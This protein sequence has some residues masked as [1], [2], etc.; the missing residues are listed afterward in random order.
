MHYSKV[1]ALDILEVVLKKDDYPSAAF[2][3]RNL[4]EI[5]RK[6][7]SSSTGKVHTIDDTEVPGRVVALAGTTSTDTIVKLHFVYVIP[8]KRNTQVIL[9]LMQVVTQACFG[10]HN[11]FVIVDCPVIN[12]LSGLH[13]FMQ[14]NSLESIEG[15]TDSGEKVITYKV[16]K[17]F[18]TEMF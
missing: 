11:M 4:Q 12:E 7:I 17:E 2:L 18:W 6:I 8:K 9:K 10:P 15:T 1:D 13:D 3:S 16:S 14:K 5:K